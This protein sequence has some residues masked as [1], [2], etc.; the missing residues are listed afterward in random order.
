MAVIAILNNFKG[1]LEKLATIL[2]DI[3]QFSPS[4]SE[5]NTA[6]RV[7]SPAD[8][9][10]NISWKWDEEKGGEKDM[11]IH[12]ITADY[13]RT[14]IKEKDD[15]GEFTMQDKAFISLKTKLV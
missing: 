6:E 10:G 13:L 4:E 14:T 8:A 1:S 9:E 12:E 5:W 2:E 11:E 3:K 7:I 15:A